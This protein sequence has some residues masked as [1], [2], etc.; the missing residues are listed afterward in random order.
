[1]CMEA[2][3]GRVAA[4]TRIEASGDKSDQL[5]TVED[6]FD[7]PRLL[8]ATV[9]G[10]VAQLGADLGAA[11]ADPLEFHQGKLLPHTSMGWRVGHSV[12]TGRC[13]VESF[14]RQTLCPDPALA[15][16]D[17]HAVDPVGGLRR[18]ESGTLS[19]PTWQFR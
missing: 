4:C 19:T 5:G 7:Q 6:V 1:M 15:G 10:R 18:A 9:S 11:A 13:L 16:V 2:A 3:R 14:S 12:R 8:A 17:R